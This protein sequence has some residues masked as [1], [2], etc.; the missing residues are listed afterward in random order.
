MTEASGIP[1]AIEIDGANRHDVKLA[2][3]TLE[4]III[5]RPTGQKQ[6]LCVDQG[7]Q[8]ENV[9]ELARELKYTL[10]LRSRKDEVKKVLEKRREDG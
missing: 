2:Q 1:L 6:N 5:P 10:H 4:N 8:G 3:P 9:K 7:Y